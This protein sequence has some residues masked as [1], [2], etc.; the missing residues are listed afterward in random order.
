MW[1]EAGQERGLGHKVEFI[2][3]AARLIFPEPND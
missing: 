3:I 2:E 1:L